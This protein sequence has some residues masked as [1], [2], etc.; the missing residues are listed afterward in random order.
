MLIE[1]SQPDTKVGEITNMPNTES[2]KKVG[3]KKI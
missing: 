3:K 1:K 2:K